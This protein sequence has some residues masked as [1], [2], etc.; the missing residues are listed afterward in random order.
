MHHSFILQLTILFSAFALLFVEPIY[1]LFSESECMEAI[2]STLKPSVFVDICALVILTV[3]CLLLSSLKELVSEQTVKNSLVF[4]IPLTLLMLGCRISHSD[5]YTPFCLMPFFKYADVMLVALVTGIIETFCTRN[6]EKYDSTIY[7]VPSDSNILF[8][9]IATEDALGRKSAVERYAKIIMGSTNENGAFGVAVTGGWGTGKSWFMNAL[10][11]ELD[12]HNLTTFT[13]RPWLYSERELTMNFC[14]SLK[15]VLD[16]RGDDTDNLQAYMKDILESSG[17][18]G[19][20]ASFL[21]GLRTSPNREELILSVKEGLGKSSKQIFVFM[22][23]CDRLGKQELLQVFSLIR[24]T[25]DFPKLCFI[26]AYD[27][28]KIEKVLKNAGGLEYAAKMINLS[29][30]LENVSNDVIVDSFSKIIEERIDEQKI[31]EKIGELDLTP[32]ISTMRELKRFWNQVYSDYQRQKDLFNNIYFEIIDWVV[33][34]LIKYKDYDLYVQLKYTP[35]K[36]LNTFNDGWNAPAWVYENNTKRDSCRSLLDFLFHKSNMS[37][38]NDHILGIANQSWFPLYF[39]D[40]LPAGYRDHHEYANSIDD[41]T[42]ADK[43]EEWAKQKD[44]GLI[45]IIA[46]LYKY[47]DDTK[48]IEALTNYIWGMCDNQNAYL[49]M[50]YLTSGYGKDKSQHYYR[51]ASKFVTDHPLLLKIYFQVCDVYWGNDQEENPFDVFMKTTTHPLELMALMM[52]ELKDEEYTDDGAYPVLIYCIPM[53]WKRILSDDKDTDDD[54]LNMLDILHDCTFEDTFDKFVFPL[55][56][57]NPQRW[58]GATL[59]VDERQ[60]NDGYL[61]LKTRETHAIFGKLENCQKFIAQI[62]SAVSD[63][64]KPYVEEY[65]TLF[66]H[67]KI[68]VEQINKQ[69]G[70]ETITVSISLLKKEKFPLL[71]QVK[72]LGR[73]V[74]IPIE[75]ALDQFVESPFWKNEDI[76]IKRNNL[77]AYFAHTI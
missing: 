35:S 72:G 6:Q 5:E 36:L 48:T 69:K 25:C 20:I 26:L 45:Y 67:H 75:N 62:K 63:E 59:K 28:E 1:I 33:L 77:D 55:I 50:S 68:I 19:C 70:A 16:K 61:L 11:N 23:E 24:N 3:L 10:K 27:T 53:L 60:E 64:D 22:D 13:F 42:F 52:G 76:R 40:K 57:K 71:S 32:Y 12:K 41:D 31:K 73:N 38:S 54:T 34:E 7:H 74:F 46:Y 65:D 58:L 37:G 47:I 4:T 8:D 9:D 49:E 18:I 2:F 43:M 39:S 17:K 30:P 44:K 66:N 29:I 21:L 56:I 15:S 14:K 51:F